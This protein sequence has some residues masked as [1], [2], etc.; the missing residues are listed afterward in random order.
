MPDDIPIPYKPWWFLFYSHFLHPSAVIIIWL[1]PVITYN[2]PIKLTINTLCSTKWMATANKRPSWQTIILSNWII[3]W[4]CRG[5]QDVL[6][7]FLRLTQSHSELQT[8]RLQTTPESK[9]NSSE[10]EPI[11]RYTRANMGIPEHFH[12]FLHSRTSLGF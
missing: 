11:Q 4:V 8:L 7:M 6:L 12:Q 9:N 10:H 2:T 5:K 3:W 1:T